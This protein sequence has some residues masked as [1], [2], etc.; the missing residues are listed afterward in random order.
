MA[1]VVDNVSL[2]GGLV[3]GRRALCAH[4]QCPAMYDLQAPAHKE[5]PR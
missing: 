3:L 1:A 4:Q 5:L 2:G